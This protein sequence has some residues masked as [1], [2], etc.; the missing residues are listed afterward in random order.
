MRRRALLA[1][2]LAVPALAQRSP[3]PVLVPQDDAVAAGWRRDVL[4][5]WGDAV[6]PDAPAF[7]PARITADAAS[8]QMGWDARLVGVAVPPVATDG[9]PRAVLLLTHPTVEPAM[10][11]A[12]GRD[13]ADIAARLQ[14]A[15]V[16]NV[17]R[18][19]SRWVVVSGGFQNRRLHADTLTRLTGPGGSGAA[20][21]L[22][23]LS[24][25][26]ATPWGTALL[27]EREP[28][29]W[30]NRLGRPAT[31]APKH[32]RVIELDPFDPIA[33]PARRTALGW[34]G[35]ADVAAATA[36]D[37]RAVVYALLAR[38]M[39]LRFV[40]AGPA[41]AD[42]LDEGTL[43]V[44][45]E[46]AGGIAWRPVP[47]HQGTTADAVG[48][49]ALALDA[50]AVVTVCP[51]S[52]RVL[53][54]TNSQVLALEP[55]AGDHAADAF[56]RTQVLA[57]D[58]VG[59][60]ACTA[61]GSTLFVGTDRQGSSWT[62]RDTLSA[63]RTG[64]AFQPDPTIYRLPRG[65]GLGGAAV[66]QDGTVAAMVRRPG[67]GPQASAGAPGTRWPTLIETDSP[68]STV[69]LLSRAA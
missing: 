69:V 23:G 4:L 7:N 68:R 33:V 47:A 32:G 8:T 64:G 9:L 38:G 24:G 42:A 37:G 54:G 62:A 40:S 20:T 51:R 53:V 58:A 27:A 63:Y 6:T 31:E 30:L 52:N 41:G 60:L 5:R 48:G 25:G 56:G 28:A 36:P 65:A 39:L 17:A 3:P 66:L 61:D 18:L 50:P 43:S 55:P 11:F 22:L 45:A 12:D 57:Q 26:C 59:A 35:F 14:G 16:V 1:T 13:R 34:G 44:A 10:V 2:A 49:A 21:G 15:S 46:Q 19:G 29:A 67:F